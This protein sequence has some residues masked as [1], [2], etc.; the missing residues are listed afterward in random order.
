[1]YKMDVSG[2]ICKAFSNKDFWERMLP[3]VC[4]LVCLALLRCNSHLCPPPA[5]LVKWTYVCTYEYTHMLLCA[6]VCEPRK[7]LIYGHGTRTA[8]VGLRN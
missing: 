3:L 6:Q 1:M 5:S 7:R 2:D 4:V 8:C